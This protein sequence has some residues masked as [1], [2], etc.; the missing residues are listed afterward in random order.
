VTKEVYDDGSAKPKPP[1][2]GYAFLVACL[3]IMVLT[4]GGAIWGALGGALGMGCVKVSANQDMPV[5]ARVGI[6]LA[7][8]ATLWIG[9]GILVAVL[10]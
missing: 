9:V 1:P 5:G 6:C 10:T 7:I 4:K 8:T 3:A 2:W